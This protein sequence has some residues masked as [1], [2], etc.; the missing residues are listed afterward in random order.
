MCVVWL[1]ITA[2]AGSCFVC[3]NRADSSIKPKKYLNKIKYLQKS[4]VL[5]ILTFAARGTLAPNCGT[6]A[7]HYNRRLRLQRGTP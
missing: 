3:V 4:I 1:R 6:S 5:P 2:R 7:N